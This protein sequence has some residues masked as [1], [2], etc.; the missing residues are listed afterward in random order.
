MSGYL[1][2]FL[3]LL[4]AGLFWLIKPGGSA[5]PTRASAGVDDQAA[6]DAAEA[7]LAGEMEPDATP[8]EAEEDSKD[9]GPGAAKP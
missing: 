8:E 4:A 5:A 2:V 6:L 3:V 9:W 1:G 7:E